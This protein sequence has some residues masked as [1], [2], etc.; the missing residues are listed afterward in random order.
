MATTQQ[1]MTAGRTTAGETRD[2][3]ATAYRGRDET[4]RFVAT[5]EFW[6]TIVGVAAVA[7]IYNLASDASLDLWRATLLAS[8]MGIAY[9]VSRGISKSGSPRDRWE[10]S[11]RT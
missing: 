4:R 5:S 3:T 10:S 9:I 8:A 11:H 6:I 7:V 1:D 2:R